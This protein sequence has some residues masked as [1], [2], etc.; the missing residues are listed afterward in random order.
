M[1]SCCSLLLL[2]SF[3]IGVWGRGYKSQAQAAVGQIP[4]A[5]VLAR[6]GQTYRELRTYEL[7]AV[8]SGSTVSSLGVVP[9][10]E[11]RVSLAADTGGKLK[12][13]RDNNQGGLLMVSNGE[14]TWTFAPAQ[15]KFTR[16]QVAADVASEDDHDSDDLLGQ[17]R[18]LLISRYTGIEQYGSSATL[19]REDRLK[20]GSR[21]IDCYV[22]AF[23]LQDT[24]HKLW[25]DEQNFLI[26]RHEEAF[27]SG[28]VLR[29]DL[30]GFTVNAPLE[31]GLFD[32]TPP[33]RSAEV[34]ELNIPGVR[35]SLVGK[36]A[37]DF[38]L[39][40]LDGASVALGD[41]Q[42]KIVMLDFW[43]T[44]CPPCRKELP[45]IAKLYEEYKDKG[46][47]VLGINAEDKATVEHYL[48]KQGL[49]LPVLMDSKRTANKLY[50]CH[51]IPTVVV[52]N[53]QGLVVAH[54]VGERSEDDLVAALKSA[55]LP[56]AASARN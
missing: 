54:Y 17:V 10:S 5:Q 44:W 30:K 34:N 41:F 9:L 12:L 24:S 25:V 20:V 53:G 3:P 49:T 43:A 14:T 38:T 23:T 6:V 37:E 22:I 56:A 13:Y 39:K 35:A 55:G 2:A 31:P 36:R 15:H 19:Q 48:G 52:I 51:A 32:F 46:V 21:K 33:A 8:V 28:G 47:V 40:D 4:A 16:E 27:K 11:S 7:D 1:T 18:H 42:G 45:T 26:L 50:G 29:L